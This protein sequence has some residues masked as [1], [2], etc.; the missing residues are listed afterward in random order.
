MRKKLFFDSLA[1]NPLIIELINYLNDNKFSV[2]LDLVIFSVLSNNYKKCGLSEWI[3]IQLVLT[4]FSYLLNVVPHRLNQKIAISIMN[5]IAISYTKEISLNN[6]I[7][8]LAAFPQVMRMR[9]YPKV[10]TAFR[11]VRIIL[12]PIYG[13]AILWKIFLFKINFQMGFQF[14]TLLFSFIFYICGVMMRPDAEENGENYFKRRKN[15]GKIMISSFTLMVFC[16]IINKC[17]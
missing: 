6:S 10:Y 9:S 15:H 13:I 1:D 5:I 14:Y 17:V 12:G 8:Y 11:R 4:L 3:I 2:L 7:I 16:D